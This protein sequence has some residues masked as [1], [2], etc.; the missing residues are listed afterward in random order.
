M[1]TLGSR[2]PRWLLRRRFRGAVVFLAQCAI[3]LTAVAV[4]TYA[5]TT[6]QER[7]IRDATEQRVLDVAHSLAGLDQV[8]QAIGTPTAPQELQPLADLVAEAS[9]VD[10]VVITDVEG[11]R[12]THPSPELRGLRVST[13]P[14]E[15]LAG[16]VFVGTETGTIGPTLRAKVPV[17]RDGAVVGTA[18][19]GILESEIVADHQASIAALVPWVI[20]AL[21]VGGLGATLLS[22]MVRRRVR[23][24]EDE[25]AVL[26]AQRRMAH[27]LREQTHEFRTQ[28]HAV[29]GL[30][31]S[32]EAGAALE[33]IAELAPVSGTEG[34]APDIADGR[35]RAVLAAQEEELRH[36]G[37]ALVLD[38]L[39]SV[40]DGGLGDD[41]ITVVANLVRNAMEASGPSG[42]VKV[43]VHAD[44]AGVEI[45][46]SDNGPGVPATALPHLFQRGFTTK[47]SEPGHDRGVGLSLVMRVVTARDG[48]VEV[49][50][51]EA[52]GARFAVTMPPPKAATAARSVPTPAGPLR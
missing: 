3:V 10:Y 20:A 11:I 9:G 12:I 43:L 50:R 40:P 15:P 19:V 45:V 5:A 1:V 46:V 4:T 34:I 29:Y 23:R 35:L 51:S 26:E 6:V 24:L 38:P 33:Y 8:Q 52:G 22:A 30:I 37:G 17:Y 2:M 39:C 44:E 7:S 49:G 28:I 27:A 32:G 25:V 14:T 18:S 48:E 13:D 42:T 31:E 47:D 16:R 21:L 36:G 41:D